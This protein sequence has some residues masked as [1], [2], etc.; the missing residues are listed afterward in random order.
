MWSLPWL[1]KQGSSVLS[2]AAFGAVSFGSSQVPPHPVQDNQSHVFGQGIQCIRV[3]QEPCEIQRLPW[4]WSDRDV[5]GHRT[6]PSCWADSPWEMCL[7]AA[8]LGLF[9]PAQLLR[10][11]LRADRDSFPSAH[12]S[13]FAKNETEMKTGLRHPLARWQM[14]QCSSHCSRERRCRAW[15]IPAPQCTSLQF[16]E[17]SHFRRLDPH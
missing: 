3:A 1:W 15:Y 13:H 7:A 14:L 12:C 4:L 2:H 5:H 10:T 17:L 11:V 16:P 8:L 9:S 6:G